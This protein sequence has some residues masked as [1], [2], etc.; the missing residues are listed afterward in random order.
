MV[1]LLPPTLCAISSVG[2]LGSVRFVC[3]DAATMQRT[4][5]TASCVAEADRMVLETFSWLVGL[6]MI[7]SLALCIL[8]L[9]LDSGHFRIS[10]KV[11]G[12]MALPGNLSPRWADL[13]ARR[14]E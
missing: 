11:S 9:L 8:R 7:L 12:K 6:V 3:L 10:R 2:Q 14:M 1:N 13:N 4:H 5:T